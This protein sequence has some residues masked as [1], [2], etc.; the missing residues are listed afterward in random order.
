MS[1]IERGKEL[2]LKEHGRKLNLKEHEE[3]LHHH[4]PKPL[5]EHEL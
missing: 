1:L 3:S 2:D 5:H 4:F